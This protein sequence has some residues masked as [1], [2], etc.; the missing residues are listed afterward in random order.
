MY[1]YQELLYVSYFRKGLSVCI[2][3]D[4]IL[5]LNYKWKEIPRQRC[6]F[7]WKGTWLF[8]RC[9]IIG[10]TSSDSSRLAIVRSHIGL[11]GPYYLSSRN[12][13]SVDFCIFTEHRVLIQN[14]SSTKLCRKSCNSSIGLHK[15]T[16]INDVSDVRDQFADQICSV[17]SWSTTV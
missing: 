7:F 14:F 3:Q 10:E 9:E 6:K 15:C 16:V 1:I 2:Q 5:G 11:R 13:N 17:S 8:I 12:A 4:P